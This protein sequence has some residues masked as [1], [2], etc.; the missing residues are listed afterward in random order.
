[1]TNP[2]ERDDRDYLVLVNAKGQH[3]LWPTFA[4]IPAG[5]TTAGPPRTRAECLD[6]ISTHWTDLCPQ[7]PTVST[8]QGDNEQ[9]RP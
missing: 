8:P 1:M 9:D 6:H 2:F 3:S 7:T 4:G 5:W